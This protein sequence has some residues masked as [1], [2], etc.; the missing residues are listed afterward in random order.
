MGKFLGILLLL[1]ALPARAGGGSLL[2]VPAGVPRWTETADGP[3]ETGA[4][5]RT[6]TRLGRPWHRVGLRNPGAVE[7]LGPLGTGRLWWVPSGIV[8]RVSRRVKQAAGA[9]ASLRSPWGARLVQRGQVEA[10]AL[11]QEVPERL[12]ILGEDGL[13]AALQPLVDLRH[14][15]GLRVEVV[16]V[17]SIGADASAIRSFLRSLVASGTPPIGVLLVGDASGLPPGRTADGSASDWTLALPEDGAWV[18][19]F[20][21]SRMPARG[22]EDVRTMVA[23]TL[24][25]EGEVASGPDGQW[26]ARSALVSSSEG[27]GGPDDDQVSE[28]LAGLLAG[29]DQEAPDRLYRSLGADRADRLIE[30]MDEGRGLVAYLGHG[31]GFSWA[32]MEPPFDREAA[33]SLANV[34]RTPLVLDVSCANGRFDLDECLAET[35]LHLGSPEAPA[36]AVAVVSATGDTPWDEPADLARLLLEALTGSDRPLLGEALEGARLRLVAGRGPTPEVREV[37]EKTVLLGD[38]RV[39]FRTRAPSPMSVQAPERAVSG[40]WTARVRQGPWPLLGVAVGLVPAEGDP[41]RRVSDDR[42]MVSFGL[43]GLSGALEWDASGPDR[44][45]V[46]GKVSREDS[47]C[48]VLEAD[49]PVWPC[50][51]RVDLR[52]RGWQGSL[53]PAVEVVGAEGTRVVTL[54][55]GDPEEWTGV[56]A[57]GPGGLP[58]AGPLRAAPVGCP[59]AAR[60]F[61]RDCEAPRVVGT[62]SR[63]LDARRVEWTVWTDEEAAGQAGVGP[64]PGVEEVRRRDQGTWLRFVFPD[65][66][67]GEEAFLTLR[68]WDRAGNV[69]VLAGPEWSLRTPPCTPDCAGRTCG[70]DGCGGTCGPGCEQGQSCREGRCTGGAGCAWWYVPGGGAR[71]EACVCQA[72]SYCCTE[73]WDEACSWRCEALCG[74]CGT[75]CVPS[76]GERQCGDNGCGGTCGECPWGRTCAPDGRCLPRCRPACEDRECGDDG[77]GGS[78]GLC[79]D[80]WTGAF[81]EDGCR[82][83]RCR[84]GLRPEPRTAWAGLPREGG[85]PEVGGGLSVLRP[86]PEAEDAGQP[87][88]DEAP[89]DEGSGEVVETVEDEGSSGAPEEAEVP[90]SAGGCQGGAGH[91]FPLMGWI[92]GWFLLRRRRG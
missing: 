38:L 5:A 14:R 65:R 12:V 84:A 49:P 41:R 62:G 48:G 7:D 56:L 70:D 89:S 59:G 24:A 45:P 16:A 33:A 35:L 3:S 75:G 8:G 10:L 88:G 36:G 83:G 20:P 31:S 82:E 76:C 79:L 57:L 54:Q 67:P 37:L 53:P 17:S 50:M 43:E 61:P 30:A 47:A 28:G 55:P 32:T 78:C 9:G 63:M 29:V 25:W 77:C 34:G 23:R 15:Q 68:L 44:V 18:A 64:A 21:V 72:A 90:R 11:V 60:E 71:C 4:E 22:V 87:G 74:G 80:P 51:G 66:E 1:A 40:S 52:L 2:W 58:S 91:L 73:R 92:G 69:R 6:W 26:L 27:V 85:G 81:R 19:A 86:V 39:P 42:G 46:Q 13:L